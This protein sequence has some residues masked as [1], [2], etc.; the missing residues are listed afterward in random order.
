MMMPPV[1]HTDPHHWLATY[2]G[3]TA[4]GLALWLG[5]LW[6][7]VWGAVAVASVAYA[8][9]EVVQARSVAVPLVWD[10]ILDWLGVT[11]G[12]MTGA[13]LWAHGWGGAAWCVASCLV[14]GYAGWE[15]R[16]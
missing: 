6:A 15:K 2:G 9:F 4:I 5:C 8:A 1:A 11:F 13:F 7:G 3:H 12:A 14:I 16:R 10:S